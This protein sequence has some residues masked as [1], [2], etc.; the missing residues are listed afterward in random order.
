[1][2]R[3]DRECGTD[4]YSEISDDHYLLIKRVS[5]QQSDIRKFE[6]V[7]IIVKLS[8]AIY[9]YRWGQFNRAHLP[10]SYIN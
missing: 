9:G 4:V 5:T 1:M 6:Y 10:N 8:S 3:E 2:L 7:G